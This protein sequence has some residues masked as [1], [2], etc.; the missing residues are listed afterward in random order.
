[1]DDVKIERLLGA[2]SASGLGWCIMC[3]QEKPLNEGKGWGSVSMRCQAFSGESFC[4]ECMTVIGSSDREAL[5]AHIK[6]TFERLEETFE[7]H[8]DEHSLNFLG[9]IIDGD[10]NL[11]LL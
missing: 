11:V 9:W 5:I 1:M 8:E 3:Q 4:P 7:E 6:P 10:L 2:L